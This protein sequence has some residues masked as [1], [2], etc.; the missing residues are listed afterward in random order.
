MIDPLAVLSDD[1]LAAMTRRAYAG[2][3]AAWRDLNKPLPNGPYSP[4]DGRTLRMMQHADATSLDD[5]YETLRAESDR[6]KQ[7]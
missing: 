5:W 6:R 1:E 3:A 2:A 4:D 7:A